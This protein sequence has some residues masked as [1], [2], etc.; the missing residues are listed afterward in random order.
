MN[1]ESTGEPLC[2]PLRYPG[3][4]AFLCDYMERFLQY[5]NLRPKLFVEPFAG[6]ASVALYLLG[7]GLIDKI[8]LYDIN[9]LITSFWITVFKDGTWLRDK[10]CKADI[11]LDEW[12]RLH[13]LPLNG[14]RV[15]AWKCLFLNRTSFSGIMASEAGPLGGKSQASKFK[16]DCRF[17]RDTIQV[18]LKELW[19]YRNLIENIDVAEWQETINR[20]AGLP[21][22]QQ[23]GLFIYLDPPFFHKAER[24]YQY[25]FKPEDHESV[26]CRLSKLNLPW[27]LS[28]DHCPEA[29]ALLRKYHLRY[30]L[31][32]VCYSSSANHHQRDIK[33][34]IIASNMPLMKGTIKC[35]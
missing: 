32:Q 8:A 14:H 21:D 23:K 22:K 24:L 33:K 16:I 13:D 27:L 18:R 15:N 29:I 30:Q 1:K 20:Y 35:Q 11:T 12:I 34:E 19:K 7:K 9:P 4:K 3:G 5:N 28:Y 17:Y 2:S 10:V 6:G 26:I 31:M 25:Y